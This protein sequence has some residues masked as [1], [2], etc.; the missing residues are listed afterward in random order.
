MLPAYGVCY[1]KLNSPLNQASPRLD[2]VIRN[3]NYLYRCL[4]T[5]SIFRLN[6]RGKPGP[7]I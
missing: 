1:A 5:Q 2:P 6:A 3:Q 7:G 4:R